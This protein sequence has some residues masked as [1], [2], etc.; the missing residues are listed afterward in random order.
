MHIGDTGVTDVHRER[1]GG[2]AYHRRVV[3][4]RVGGGVLDDGR[5]I[6]VE[7]QTWNLPVP[8]GPASFPISRDRYRLRTVTDDGQLGPVV[9]DDL[10]RADVADLLHTRRAE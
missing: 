1:R 10:R 2:R 9:R 8:K 6:V 5:P 4:E 7:H 3:W